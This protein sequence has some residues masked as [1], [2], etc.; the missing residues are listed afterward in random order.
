MIAFSK[1]LLGTLM[2]NQGLMAALLSAFFL[3]S[4]AT[5]SSSDCVDQARG[6]S[7]LKPCWVSQKPEEGLVLKGNRTSWGSDGWF[8]AQQG[9]FQQAVAIFAQQKSG[10]NVTTSAVVHSST[11]V[12]S[13]GTR[14]HVKKEVEVQNITEISQSA[15][16]VNIRV[17]L[18][19]Y[20][21]YPPTDTVYIWAKEAD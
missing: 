10:N 9:L 4:C 19:D 18:E 3:T 20:Y 17:T 21:Y 1:G 16:G 2:T 13:S 11:E 8:K 12:T 7:Q 15:E 5:L 6:V 14:E